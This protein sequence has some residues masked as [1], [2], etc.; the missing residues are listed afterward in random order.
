VRERLLAAGAER[1]FAGMM[2]DRRYDRD[3]ELVAK[4]EVLRLRVFRHGDGRSE[5]VLGWKGATG[6]SPEGYKVRR[7]L[8]FEVSSSRAAPEALLEAL[9]YRQ[10]YAVERF[11]EYYHLGDTDV[12]LEWYP[13]MDVLIEVEGNEAGIESALAVIGL[14]RGEFTPEPLRFFAERYGARTGRSAALEVA[15]LPG[16]EAPSWDRR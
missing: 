1:G 13:R 16:D 5:A 8:E 10:I 14:P 7:E 3:G 4:D 12:R 15:E 11:V 6:V 2:L 9:G